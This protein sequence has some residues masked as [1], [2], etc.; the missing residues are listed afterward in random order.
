MQDTN[1]P[2]HTFDCII[3]KGLLDSLLCGVK[4][5][6]AVENYIREVCSLSFSSRHLSVSVSLG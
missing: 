5:S 6:E 2:E 1:L 4:G 3:D